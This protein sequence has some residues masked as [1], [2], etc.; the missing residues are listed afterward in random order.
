MSGY[1]SARVRREKTW[2]DLTLRDM[3]HSRSDVARDAES[4]FLIFSV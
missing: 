2:K 3:E 1:S 4:I